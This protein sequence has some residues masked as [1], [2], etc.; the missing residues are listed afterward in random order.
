MNIWDRVLGSLETKVNPQSFATWLRPTALARDEGR[1]IYVSV[2]SELFASWLTKN[3][4]DLII[5]INLDNAAFEDD[6]EGELV[7]IFDDI[8]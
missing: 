3:Y 1:E 5:K 8:G 6:P 7:R 4:M 2:P